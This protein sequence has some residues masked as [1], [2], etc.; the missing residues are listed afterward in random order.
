V[1][2]CVWLHTVVGA[3]CR[4][5]CS[6]LMNRPTERA[7]LPLGRSLRIGDTRGN[8]EGAF[9]NHRMEAGSMPLEL[10]P[11]LPRSAMSREQDFL[12]QRLLTGLSV[13][14]A[15]FPRRG[16]SPYSP[17][18]ARRAVRPG[19]SVRRESS[20]RARST[21]PRV[22]VSSRDMDSRLSAAGAR[23]SCM[24]LSGGAGRRLW[25]SRGLGRERRGN[26]RILRCNEGQVLGRSSW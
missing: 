26:I 11:H 3:K 7:E 13:G 24:T 2:L 19:T 9:P 21:H 4:L 18:R 5:A 10:R 8:R 17:E 6:S 25:V 22:S 14:K 23:D 20:C 15:Q 12:R 1:G 16:W